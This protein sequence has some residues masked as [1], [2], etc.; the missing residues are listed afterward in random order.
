MGKSGRHGNVGIRNG[1]VDR[2]MNGFDAK[3]R[4]YFWE[5]VLCKVKE[6]IMG[7]EFQ[8][9]RLHLRLSK[10]KGVYEICSQVRRQISSVAYAIGEL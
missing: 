6:N 7:F 10:V 5:P 1:R 3:L 9:K 4:S 2:E 8:Q